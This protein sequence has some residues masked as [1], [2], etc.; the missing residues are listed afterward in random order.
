LAVANNFGKNFAGKTA[1]PNDESPSPRGVARSLIVGVSLN[2]ATPTDPDPTDNP[3]LNPVTGLTSYHF[4]LPSVDNTF[5]GFTSGVTAL[6]F[7]NGPHATEDLYENGG[8]ERGAY[9]NH[10]NQYINTVS[11]YR[12]ASPNRVSAPGSRFI[13]LVGAFWD[14]WGEHFGTPDRYSIY[15]DNFLKYGLTTAADPYGNALLTPDSNDGGTEFYGFALNWASNPATSPVTTSA[16]EIRR[17]DAIGGSEVGDWDYDDGDGEIL[18][19]MH[20][21]S[22]CRGGIYT[23]RFPEVT[24]ATDIVIGVTNLFRDDDSVL[25]GVEVDV[26]S[27]LS[28]RYGFASYRTCSPAISIA[29][30]SAGDGTL[31]YKDV[32]NGLVWVKLTKFTNPYVGIPF[33]G[34][35]A[36][37]YQT[38]NLLITQA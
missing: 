3:D 11:S 36:T 37:L 21:W 31:Y 14:P 15:D 5:T 30:V 1:V 17:L 34:T 23:W 24:P 7:G 33:S 6:G 22:A 8:V 27:G 10:G 35:W 26:S 20:T 19:G 4:T 2:N 32:S 28:V 9:F 16:M 12:H 13:G 18:G 29:A 25:I 38:M